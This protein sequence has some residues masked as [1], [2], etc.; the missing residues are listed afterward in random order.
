MGG[1]LTDG[2]KDKRLMKITE[3][4]SLDSE[5]E[6]AEGLSPEVLQLLGI[7]DRKRG[8]WSKETKKE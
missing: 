7:G 3:G 2:I 5:L 4:G 6:E 8:R 1:C